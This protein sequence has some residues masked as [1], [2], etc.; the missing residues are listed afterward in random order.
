MIDAEDAADGGIRRGEFCEPGDVTASTGGLSK[1]MRNEKKPT[2]DAVGFFY[3]VVVLL[4][5][6]GEVCDS[7]TAALALLMT[8]AAAWEADFS[9]WEAMCAYL[10]VTVGLL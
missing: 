7:M 1:K 4:D 5:D 2:A 9:A 3:G 6:M 8:S 10:I